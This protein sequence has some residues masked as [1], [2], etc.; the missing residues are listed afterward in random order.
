MAPESALLPPPLL[1]QGHAIT[2]LQLLLNT[3]APNVMSL[4][5][6]PGGGS[7]DAENLLTNRTGSTIEAAMVE[8][9]WGLR[10][11]PRPCLSPPLSSPNGGL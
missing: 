9:V 11:T 3:L 4:G 5:M 8:W 10:L 2:L 7:G 1:L 6:M